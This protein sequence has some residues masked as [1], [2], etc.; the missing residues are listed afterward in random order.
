MATQDS[1]RCRFNFGN[2]VVYE[3]F[4]CLQGSSRRLQES[5]LWNPEST[6][7]CQIKLRHTRGVNNQTEPYGL[8]QVIKLVHWV[9]GCCELDFYLDIFL[10]KN[11]NVLTIKQ[12]AVPCCF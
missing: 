12:Y 9:V 4:F 8:R 11:K 7:C 3:R 5:H 10:K 6:I 2:I 1:I